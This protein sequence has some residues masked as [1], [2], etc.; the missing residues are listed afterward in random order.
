MDE[1]ETK[2]NTPIL[3]I[4]FNRPQKTQIVFD[5]IAAVKPKHLLIV[6]DGARTNIPGEAELCKKTREIVQKIDWDCKFE[7]NFSDVNL[8]CRERVS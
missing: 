3:F 1:L 7:Y 4:I 6:S 8:G 5:R 2:F